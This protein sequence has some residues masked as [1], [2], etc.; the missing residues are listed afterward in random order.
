MKVL[1][2]SGGEYGDC[3]VKHFDLMDYNDDKTD[4]VLFWG[5][6]SLEKDD[7]KSQY[8]SSK[9]K[10]FINTA[11][12]CEIIGGYVDILK[13]SY[14]DNVYTI[15]PYT[16]NVL[17]TT[18][19]KMS[20]TVY[21]PIC[22]PY[23]EK[24]FT[25]YENIQPSDKTTDVI[26]YGNLHHGLYHSLVKSISKFNYAFSTIS[27]HNHTQ[28]TI[29]LITHYDITSQEKWDLISKCKMSVGFNL[30]FLNENHISNLKSTP[31]I[32]S[33][34]HIDIAYQKQMLPQFK[35]RMVEAAACKT[36]MLMYKDEWNV[37]ENW[38]EPNKHFLYWETFEELEVLIKDISE[39]YEKYWHIVEAANQHVK[40][41]TIDN[42]VK[43][44]NK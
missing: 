24:Y 21:T 16:A 35:T 10:V 1:Y 25:K 15:C 26:Y 6:N 30:I 11:M 39:N 38:F 31:N 17:N 40:Q 44:I 7:L 27:R 13:Q 5:W 19:N 2:N 37:I 9:D 34:K 4:R 42:L 14:F 8:E 43:I 32:E 3:I 33:F 29:N 41:Y 18:P 23:P 22:F 12:P 20:D 28:E 36:L